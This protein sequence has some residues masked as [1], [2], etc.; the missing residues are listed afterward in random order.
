MKYIYNEHLATQTIFLYSYDNVSLIREVFSFYDYIV[1][2]PALLRVHF[3]AIMLL[4]LSAS[5]IDL[6]QSGGDDE[7]EL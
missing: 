4:E 1:L 3:C 7:T 6:V 5:I 2:S